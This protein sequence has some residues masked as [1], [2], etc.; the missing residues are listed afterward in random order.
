MWIGVGD[1][2]PYIER[3][4]LEAVSAMQSVMH[5]Q[6]FNVDRC[7]THAGRLSDMVVLRKCIPEGQDR[8]E[9]TVPMP[10]AIFHPLYNSEFFF[11]LVLCSFAD[12]YL[13][14]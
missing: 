6:A 2:H 5:Q 1:N 9:A 10:M 14:F 7:V 11:H 3:V 12:N 8:F 13:V 4:D